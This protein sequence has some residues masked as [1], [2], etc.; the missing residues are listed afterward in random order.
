MESVEE[1]SE[2]TD[3]GVRE[4]FDTGSQRDSEEGKGC[5]DLL[6]M[7]ALHRLCVYYENGARKYEDR[8]WE[9]GQ[10]LTR[11]WRSAFRHLCKYMEGRRDEDHMAAACWNILSFIETENRIRLGFLD[12]VLDD[13]P[14][15][16]YRSPSTTW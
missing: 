4:A 10:P 6:P 12:P 7:H 5:P 13:M 15:Q 14:Q 1:Y 2:V 3:S 11:Y 16:T 8:N 9:K